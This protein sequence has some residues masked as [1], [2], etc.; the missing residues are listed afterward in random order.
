MYACLYVCMYEKKHSIACMCIFCFD[1]LAFRRLTVCDER[2]MVHTTSYSYDIYSYCVGAYSGYVY[3]VYSYLQQANL[4][5]LIEQ[6][7]YMYV[8]VYMYMYAHGEVHC[9]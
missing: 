4:T 6:M 7:R 9:W 1:I 5:N 2:R 3:V 8:C